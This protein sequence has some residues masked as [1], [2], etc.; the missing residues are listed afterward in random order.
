LY[1]QHL[2]TVKYVNETLCQIEFHDRLALRNAREDG[3]I[4]SKHVVKRCYIRNKRKCADGDI[5]YIYIY[6]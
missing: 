6:I 3:F 1:N 4:M 2:E 5:S